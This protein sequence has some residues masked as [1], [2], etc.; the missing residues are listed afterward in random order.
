VRTGGQDVLT[1]DCFLLLIAGQ[2][3]NHWVYDYSHA[4][5]ILV[6]QFA[7]LARIRTAAD[8]LSFADATSFVP[9]NL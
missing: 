2:C 1:R 6:A 4:S 9:Y 3:N 8:L 7:R 5:I